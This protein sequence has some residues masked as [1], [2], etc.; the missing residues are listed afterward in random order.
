M[1]DLRGNAYISSTDVALRLDELTRDLDN[2]RDEAQDAEAAFDAARRE[3][4]RDRA[5]L[6]FA[7]RSGGDEGWI[8]EIRYSLNDAQA[9][10]DRAKNSLN[11]AQA[12]LDEAEN[13]THE[14]MHALRELARKGEQEVSRWSEGETLIRDFDEAVKQFADD[15]IVELR[16]GGETY[17]A[18]A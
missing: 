10:L 3:V 16:F 11:D 6:D 15:I 1:R 9:A 17:I 2:L 14:E 13:D 8:E 5:E 12:A 4:E 7:V 18:R